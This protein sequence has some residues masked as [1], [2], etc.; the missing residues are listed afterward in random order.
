MC[1][2]YDGPENGQSKERRCW[3]QLHHE[4]ASMGTTTQNGA[5]LRLIS[6]I[7]SMSIDL[8]GFSAR[9]A[10]DRLNTSPLRFSVMKVTPKRWT[11]GVSEQFCMKCL[12]VLYSLRWRL[13]VVADSFLRYHAVRWVLS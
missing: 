12:Q 13:Y 1:V 11:Y 4:P 3:R 2:R 6:H 10:L 5:M 8:A 7:T 9:V